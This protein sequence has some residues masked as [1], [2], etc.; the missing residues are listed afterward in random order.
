M[1]FQISETIKAPSRRLKYSI[2]YSILY[3]DKVLFVRLC[4]SVG[5][6]ITPASGT[7]LGLSVGWCYPT[8]WPFVLADELR[9]NFAVL[10]TTWEL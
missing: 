8:T 3:K 1:I 4:V 6:G 7:P 9:G 2:R 5:R 10:H